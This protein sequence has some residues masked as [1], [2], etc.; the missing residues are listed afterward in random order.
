LSRNPYYVMQ[1]GAGIPAK[2]WPADRFAVLATMIHGASGLRGIICGGADDREIGQAICQVTSAP[3]INACGTTTINDLV[4]IISNA[5]FL[6]GND[7]GALHIAAAIGTPAVCILGAG[8]PG[9]FF[10]YQCEGGETSRLITII[11]QSFDCYGCGWFCE[12]DV[13]PGM[14][15][16]CVAT[17]TTEEVWL[18]LQEILEKKRYLYDPCFETCNS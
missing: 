13:R 11:S 15:A 3:L 9:R 1:P 10:P 17:I 18:A 8:E 7:T 16:P 6:V 5:T 14:P 2:R 12:Y 4:E